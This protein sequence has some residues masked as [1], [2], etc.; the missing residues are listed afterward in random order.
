MVLKNNR[1]KLISIFNEALNETNYSDIN[2]E[3][4]E[5]P[6]VVIYYL[7]DNIASKNEL[8]REVKNHLDKQQLVFER[9]EKKTKNIIDMRTSKLKEAFTEV[10]FFR[11]DEEDYHLKIINIDVT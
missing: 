4:I 8:L 11:G 7:L 9:L 3:T 5:L 2:S 10:N 1:S 6:E